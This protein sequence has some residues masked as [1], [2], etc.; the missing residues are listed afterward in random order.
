VRTFALIVLGL[1]AVSAFDL[2]QFA[3]LVQTGTRSND[4]VESVYN[5]LRDLKTEN[6]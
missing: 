2:A 6:L 4:A 5:L 3:T 1:V